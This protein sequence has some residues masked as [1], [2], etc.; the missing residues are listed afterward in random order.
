MSDRQNRYI[1]FEKFYKKSKSFFEIYANSTKSERL[2]NLYS[3]YIIPGGR[4]GGVDKKVIEIFY[5]SRPFSSVTR[6]G[7]DSKRIRAIERAHGATLAYERTDDG[8]VICSL[9]P[10]SSENFH[11]PEEFIILDIVK[12]PDELIKKSIWHWRFFQAYMECT[13]LDGEPNLFQ[14]ICVFYLRNVK[15]YVVNGTLQKRKL[16]KFFCEIAKYTVTVGLSGFII[17]FITR[18]KDTANS[19]QAEEMQKEVIT[20]SSNISSSASSIAES[21]KEINKKIDAGNQE[22]NENLKLLN[23]SISENASRI[24]R[25]IINIK[26]EKNTE[27]SSAMNTGK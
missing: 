16:T 22:I 13:C 18:F 2:K 9:T 19:N 7:S 5:G 11:H 6:I 8:K 12:N 14:N 10:A 24:E 27:S 26:E 1:A 3:F 20:V 21:S 17:L 4:Y 25:A 15:E 23:S